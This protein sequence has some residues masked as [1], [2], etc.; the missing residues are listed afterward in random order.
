M[1]KGVWILTSAALLASSL[2]MAQDRGVHS[3]H[4]G[5]RSYQLSQGHLS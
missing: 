4:I 1:R 5:D 2:A 3:D